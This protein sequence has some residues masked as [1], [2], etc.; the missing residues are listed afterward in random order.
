DRLNGGI[1]D[2]VYVYARGD[3]HDELASLQP[4]ELY[5]GVTGPINVLSLTEITETQVSARLEP[6]GILLMIAE[7][8]PGAGDDGSILIRTAN[9]AD[10]IADL[11]VQ[12]VD[13]D[14]GISWS[15][16]TLYSRALAGLAGIGDDSLLGSDGADTLAGEA[17]NDLLYGGY[18][19]DTYVYARGDGVD[20]I[21]E[22]TN[23]TSSNTLRLTGIL[24]SEVTLRPGAGT[25]MLVLVAPSSP[26]A[27]DGGRIV[28]SAGL[29]PVNSG[30][31]QIIFDDGT[32]WARVNFGGLI[33]ASI[34]TEGNDRI[35]GSTAADT[36]EGAGGNDVLMGDLGDDAYLFTRGDGIDQIRDTGGADVLRITG[37]AA[38]DLE[39][40]RNGA[41]GADLTIRFDDENDGIVILDALTTSAHVIERI[42]FT[43]TA[44]VVVFADVI[45]ALSAAQTT[46][47]NDV[48][49]GTNDGDDLRGGLGNDLLA[50]GSGGDT[51]RFV[52]GD[53]DD[54]ISDTGSSGT[55]RLVLDVNAADL[56]YALRLGPDGFD[57]VLRLPGERDRI[58]LEEALGT[59]QQGVEE[60]VFANGTVW[61]RDAMRNATLV[62]SQTAG[63]D[64]LWGYFGADTI[65]MG[66]GNDTAQGQGGSDT[67]VVR[68]GDG[69]DR[70][71]EVV[72]AA[73]IDVV[74]F[75]DYVSSE[76]S[77]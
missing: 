8:A 29:G 59:G 60:I 45:A 11:A 14:G 22:T 33:A 5:G 16:N 70:I 62:D 4:T 37:Y 63:A 39:F 54:R 42:E 1:G 47:G 53:G 38:A 75:R 51:Y 19:D 12:R 18:G 43:D 31:Q 49:V 73:A 72:D 64:K 57:L 32:T 30:I 26:V 3:G 7:T 66:V 69:A 27:G 50:G 46:I 61:N 58:I 34:K 76:V 28:V 74:D 35:T 17:G 77:V 36:L 6:N 55:D 44:E 65:S 23:G 48:I 15:A 21:Y 13:F 2:D 52:T 20:R 9:Y 40:T 24:A 71:V 10:G 67:Y 25:D 41:T 68:R 56:I